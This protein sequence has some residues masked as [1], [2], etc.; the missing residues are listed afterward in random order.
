MYH[1][2]GE[3]GRERWIGYERIEERRTVD[4]SVRWLCG[5]GL[6]WLMLPASL[7]LSFFAPERP[8]HSDLRHNTQHTTHNAIQHITTHDSTIQ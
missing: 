2:T 7:A 6:T 8:M 3:Q 1:E 5:D 4:K